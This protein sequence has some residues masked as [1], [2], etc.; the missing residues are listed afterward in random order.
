MNQIVEMK[1]YGGARGTARFRKA[2]TLVEAIAHCNAQSHVWIVGNPGD[3]RK[4]KVN[5]RVRTWKRD[6]ARVEVPLKYGLYE[7]FTVGGPELMERLL[8]PVEGEN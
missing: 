4:C 7:Y 2:E 1:L 3:A 5:G 6:V 8:I